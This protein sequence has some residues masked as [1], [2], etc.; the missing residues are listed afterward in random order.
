MGSVI[1]SGPSMCRS[2]VQYIDHNHD[3]IIVELGAGD[4]VIT[5]YILEKM[6]TK[7][8]LFVFEINPEL[9]EIITKI[10]DERMVLINDG[11]QYME[12]HLQRHGVEKVDTIISAI[13]FVVL[14]EELTHE[15]LRICKKILKDGGNF[16]QMHY[17]KS[18]R[19]MYQSIFGNVHT[20][21]VPLNIPPGYVFRCENIKPNH[22]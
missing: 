15:I 16:V 2:M 1:R 19:K 21:Y 18:V 12:S 7:A 4:G 6:S 10:K 5:Q 8:K 11:A 17:I 13:P 14:P 20:F 22:S 9:C 3:L